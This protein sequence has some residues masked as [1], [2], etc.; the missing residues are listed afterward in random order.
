RLSRQHVAMILKGRARPTNAIMARLA[1]AAVAVN[2]AAAE[3][4]QVTEGVRL[5]CRRIGL[6]AFARL[7]GID[8]GLLARLLTGSR[9]PSATML[10]ALRR[11]LRTRLTQRDDAEARAASSAGL[12]P[13]RTP[14]PVSAA[15][16]RPEHRTPFRC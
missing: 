14:A 2:A 7:A 10:A 12:Q 15:K 4:E 13:D 16:P 8:D 6:R 5:E 1:G 11:A 9:R 3:A